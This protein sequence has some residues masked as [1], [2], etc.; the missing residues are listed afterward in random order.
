MRQNWRCISRSKSLH[1]QIAAASKDVWLAGRLVN[2]KQ[3]L[4][5]AQ[6]LLVRKIY[7]VKFYAV[8]ILLLC[9]NMFSYYADAESGVKSYSL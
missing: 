3:R 5:N 6:F 1:L 7:T 8:D 9:I 2:L 4:L